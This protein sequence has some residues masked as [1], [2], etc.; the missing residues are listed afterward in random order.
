MSG[1]Q[2]PQAEGETQSDAGSDTE[3]TA[4]SAETTTANSDVTPGLSEEELTAVENGI[5]DGSVTVPSAT[6]LLPEEAVSILQLSDVFNQKKKAHEDAR[7]EVQ[8]KQEEWDSLNEKKGGTPDERKK[9]EVTLQKLTKEI[10]EK[11]EE[12][13]QL[14][15]EVNSI[16][17]E[18]G[19]NFAKGLGSFTTMFKKTFAEA[20]STQAPT[21]VAANS[22]ITSTMPA[23]TSVAIAPASVS[24]SPAAVTVTVTAVTITVT[25]TATVTSAEFQT[26]TVTS[27]M[28][29]LPITTVVSTA[30]VVPTTSTS[31]A[32]T[33]TSTTAP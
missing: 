24:T 10:A 4:G 20:I 11:T 29:A 17:R 30:S 33:P 16:K 12:A 26:P 2:V 13:D 32:A 31:H 22:T 6:A 1:G 9:A 15:E 8:E 23:S 3:A 19:S 14:E 7:A 18:M 28:A 5:N 21:T 27:T 25:P